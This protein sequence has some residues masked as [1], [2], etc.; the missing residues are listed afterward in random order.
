MS[1]QCEV[2][3]KKGLVGNNV[4]HSKRRTKRRQEVNL[5]SKKFWDPIQ[6]K[7]VRMKVSAKVV[8]SINKKGLL[9]VLKSY[10]EA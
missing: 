8:K 9:A 5:Q 10:Q 2:T 4:S 1:R 7:W 6:G 3:K